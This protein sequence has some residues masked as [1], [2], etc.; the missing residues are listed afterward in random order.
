M[1][2]R[3]QIAELLAQPQVKA[4]VR[5]VAREETDRMLRAHFD[6]I[7][8]PPG[9]LTYKQCCELMGVTYGTL[10]TL[11]SRR[12]LKGKD[13]LVRIDDFKAWAANYQPKPW[14]RK[15]ND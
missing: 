7:A 5:H 11:V 14:L 3:E 4:F 8:T 12:M 9:F 13:G 1:P 15:T 10:R 6:G 2:T